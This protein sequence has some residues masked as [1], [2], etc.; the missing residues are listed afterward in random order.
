M[1]QPE[2]PRVVPPIGSA[3]E[4]PPVLL[5]VSA[6]ESI[7]ALIEQEGD[8]DAELSQ[9]AWPQSGTPGAAVL[10]ESI[11]GR[12]MAR[13]MRWIRKRCVNFPTKRSTSR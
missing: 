8:F 7:A 10:G 5:A 9:D 6:L 11:H 4:H 1:E 13:T 3:V 12:E 2:A